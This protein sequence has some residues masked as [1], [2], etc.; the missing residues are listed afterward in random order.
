MSSCRLP[1]LNSLPSGP[2][3]LKTGR[4]DMIVVKDEVTTAPQTSMT[5]S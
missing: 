5:D 3:R 4:N 1:V 2:V